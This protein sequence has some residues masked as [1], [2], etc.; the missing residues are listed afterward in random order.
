MKYFLYISY[1]CLTFLSSLQV[2]HP[3]SVNVRVL[4]D[5]VRPLSTPPPPS[6]LSN[7]SPLPPPPPP[8]PTNRTFL[9]CQVVIPGPPTHLARRSGEGIG[10]G[11]I[12]APTCRL[13]RNGGTSNSVSDRV[14]RDGDNQGPLEISRVRT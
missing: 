5:P 7:P 10:Q 2:Q 3:Y 9:T 14:P 8:P 13:V 12:D 6:L 11:L 1:Q 4:P